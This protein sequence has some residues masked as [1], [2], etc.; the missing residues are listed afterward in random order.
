M[1]KVGVVDTTFARMDMGAMA[2]QEIRDNYPDAKVVRK[3]VP[4]VKDLPCECKILLEEGGCDICM[5][6]GM[7]GPKQIDKTCAH[8][9]SMGLI[10]AQLMMNKHIIEVFVHEDEASG[11]QLISII[12]DR[13]RSHA[14]NAVLLLTRPEALTRNAGKG[15]RQGKEDAGSLFKE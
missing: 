14:R 7:P 9:A 15:V 4:G 2:S 13:V 8:E 3:T 1:I 11:K 6:L 5:A 10:Q 12:E